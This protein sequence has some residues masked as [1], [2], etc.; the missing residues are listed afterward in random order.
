MSARKMFTIAICLFIGSISLQGQ[1]FNSDHQWWL[2]LGA[3]LGNLA[4]ENETVMLYASFN[5]PKSENLLLSSRY[6]FSQQLGL[7]EFVEPET[8]WD[9]S[10]LAS[11]YIKKNG[12]FFSIGTGLGLNGG[13]MRDPSLQNYLTVGLPIE[14]QLFMTLPSVGIGLVGIVNINPKTTYWGV[15]AALQFG[16]LR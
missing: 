13:K 11:Y 3:G 2:N 14:T 10:A 9:L 4:S 12:G 7:L 6:S 1:Y 16:S 5:K 15:T 8:N